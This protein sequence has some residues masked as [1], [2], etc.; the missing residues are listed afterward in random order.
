[1]NQQGKYPKS[2]APS[3]KKEPKIVA[4]NVSPIQVDNTP[5]DVQKRSQMS[6]VFMKKPLKNGLKECPQTGISDFNPLDLVEST[7]TLRNTN[8]DSQ[9]TRLSRSC[10]PSPRR[11]KDMHFRKEVDKYLHGFS[12]VQSEEDT[13]AQ[14]QGFLGFGNAFEGIDHAKRKGKT[15]DR[16]SQQSDQE[17]SELM[18]AYHIGIRDSQ[19]DICTDILKVQ[20]YEDFKNN[21]SINQPNI[22]RRSKSY[23]KQGFT[24][25]FSAHIDQHQGPNFNLY[26]EGAG[27]VRKFTTPEQNC[28]SGK[29]QKANTK[30]M[31]KSNS[32]Y[33]LQKIQSTYSNATKTNKGLNIHS[34]LKVPVNLNILFDVNTQRYETQIGVSTSKKRS[35]IETGNQKNCFT[36]QGEAYEVPS[37]IGNKFSSQ[38]NSATKVKKKALTTGYKTSEGT[39]TSQ[40]GPQ[41]PANNTKYQDFAQTAYTF[42]MQNAMKQQ[43]HHIKNHKGALTHLNDTQVHLMDSSQAHLN[44]LTNRNTTKQVKNQFAQPPYPNMNGAL[45]N[46][47]S[48]TNFFLDD[49]SQN[50]AA[51]QIRDTLNY[52]PQT[53]S[54]KSFL[55]MQQQRLHHNPSAFVLNNPEEKRGTEQLKKRFLENQTKLLKGAQDVFPRIPI[56]TTAAASGNE[57]RPA[58]GFKTNNQLQREIDMFKKQISNGNGL[59]INKKTYGILNKGN[60]TTG[61][62]MTNQALANLPSDQQQQQHII[63][64]Q[65]TLNKR[66]YNF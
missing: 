46:H 32:L 59:Q 15:I 55:Q 11:D 52:A 18:A 16:Y 43:N 30:K 23:E 5:E 64:H 36:Y 63:H 21:A 47:H 28:S 40:T 58:K 13:T 35:M 7:D 10:L 31:I 24:S 1:M 60:I 9:Q 27:S 38:K 34:K 66:L 61:R 44:V 45:T 54:K 22:L 19:S 53:S 12:F 33:K 6:S 3:S 56:S 57:S 29:T 49:K 25:Q 65:Q 17:S 42:E 39:E 51:Y 37:R 62:K 14:N 4:I 48:K 20:E 26:R 2:I 50:S 8:R 41:S